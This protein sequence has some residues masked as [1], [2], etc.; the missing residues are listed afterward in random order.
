MPVGNVRVAFCRP[1]CVEVFLDHRE[2]LMGKPHSE[3]STVCQAPA[4]KAKELAIDGEQ[5]F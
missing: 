3:S 4:R 5:A 2:Q 1:H